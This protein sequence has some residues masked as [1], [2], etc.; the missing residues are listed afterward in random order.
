ME[1]TVVLLVLAGAALHPLRDLL[2]KG[3]ANAGSGYFSVMS[4]WMAIAIAEIVVSGL[5]VTSAF[6]VWHLIL[7]SA[8]GLTTYYIGILTAMRTGDFSVYYPI[9]RS[10]PVFMVVAGW[11][12][13]GETYSA[14]VLAGVALVTLGAWLLQ[15]T[16]GADF[17]HSPKTLAV[18]LLAMAGMGTQS[19]ADAEVM[20]VL[21]VP[22]LL[23][24]GFLFALMVLAVFLL[25]RRPAEQPW[26]DALIGGWRENPWR[27]LTAGITGY[28]SYYLIL[29]AYQQ[30][31]AAVPVNS[32]RQISIPL[33]VILGGLVLRE[34]NMGSRFAWSLLLAAGIIIIIIAK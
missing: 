10:A 26:S 32:L 13:L 28:L 29:I 17:L 4:I 18:S 2:L 8:G 1:T 33:S 20:Q 11:L 6:D 27:I 24:W 7:F 3:I 22:V 21:Q 12:V 9:I 14:V 5:D 30:G 19:L 34:L 16:P 25:L 31:G 15:Y 23:F